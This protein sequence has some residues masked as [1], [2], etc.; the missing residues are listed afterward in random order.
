MKDETLLTV[1]NIIV[2]DSVVF[3]VG[4]INY[5]IYYVQLNEYLKHYGKKGKIKIVNVLGSLICE[6]EKRFNELEFKT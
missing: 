4:D 2:S 6:V 3:H 1:E 5:H